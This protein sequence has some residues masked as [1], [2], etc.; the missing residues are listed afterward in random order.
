MFSVQKNNF[1]LMIIRWKFI[2]VWFTYNF[3]FF[4][5]WDYIIN[6][7]YLKDN[8][9]ISLFLQVKSFIKW[10]SLIWK[11]RQDV[12]FY[13]SFQRLTNNNDVLFVQIDWK[14]SY[15]LNKFILYQFL[16]ITFLLKNIRISFYRTYITKGIKM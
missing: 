9:P 2:V 13:L 15:I 5:N 11:E 1:K 8:F 12:F 7:V 10:I 4:F 14:W 6:K 3:F 16:T